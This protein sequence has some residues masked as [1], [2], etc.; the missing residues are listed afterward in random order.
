VADAAVFG[1]PD[2]KWGEAVAAAVVLRAGMTVSA[3]ELRAHC[4]GSLARFKCP[5]TFDFMASLPRNSAGKLL[6]RELRSPYW[7]GSTRL[8][9][10]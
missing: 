4:N 1:I 8:I 5:R 6:R 7:Q 2:D 10:G 3:D 9:Q